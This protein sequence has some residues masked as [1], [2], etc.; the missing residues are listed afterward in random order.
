KVFAVAFTMVV[1]AISCIELDALVKL[2]EE[3][4]EITSSTKGQEAREG[5]LGRI[6][7]YGALVRCGRLEVKTAASSDKGA[8][9]ARDLTQSILMLANKKCFMCEPAV[10]IILDLVDRMP[11]KVLLTRILK[12]PILKEWLQKDPRSGHPDALLL[13]LKLFEKLPLETRN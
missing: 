13:A 1:V 11:R 3:L 4:L 10:A 7:A 5:L 6:F 12:A 9:L 2:S 8:E